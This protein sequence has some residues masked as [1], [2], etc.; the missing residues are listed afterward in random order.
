M[1]ATLLA[2][3][4]VVIPAGGYGYCL[5]LVFDWLKLV[6]AELGS[7]AG[8]RVNKAGAVARMQA[9]ARNPDI[10]TRHALNRECLQQC[11][12]DDIIS[13]ATVYTTYLNDQK[14]NQGQGRFYQRQVRW[15]PWTEGKQVEADILNA[16]RITPKPGMTLSLLTTRQGMGQR[17]GRTLATKSAMIHA[18][19][20]LYF[21][22]P[23]GS[24]RGT[25][26]L[27]DPNQG[28]L[29]MQGDCSATWAAFYQDYGSRKDADFALFKYD[30]QG[31]LYGTLA[32][33]QALGQVTP[34][35][36]V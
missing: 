8:I 11:A 19:G 29:G 10:A 21:L 6:V 24:G 36:R 18:L 34:P 23:D 27:Y 17:D 4:E 9:L 26:L 33:L 2:K 30:P 31:V 1:P 15:K 20:V 7:P 25:T 35:V 22:A 14:L 16:E 12:L 28:E 32:E 5:T 3:S 13:A